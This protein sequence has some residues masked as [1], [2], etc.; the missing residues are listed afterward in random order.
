MKFEV[1]YV[2][3]ISIADSSEWKVILN[4]YNIDNHECR[5]FP[6]GEY[7]K[8]SLYNKELLFYSC[9]IRKVKS[10]A[11]TQ[12][13]IDHFDLEKIIVVGTCA[14]I[15]SNY[16]KLDVFF[17]DKLVQYDC[18]VKGIGPLINDEYTVCLNTTNFP[19]LKTGTL[20]TGDKFVALWE[21]YIELKNN[22]ITIA[23]MESA[24]IGLVCK[25]NNV[26]C[27]VVK[28]ITDYPID[29]NNVYDEQMNTFEINTPL[30]MKK[31]LDDYLEFA[32]KNKFEYI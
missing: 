1:I 5:K 7:F 30:V 21:D 20:A 10:S 9:D 6:F 19:N 13:M 31:I 28:G 29:E 32:I 22:D 11:S 2:I 12:Y 24:A 14:G 23:D 8:L 26:E 27:V 17:P 3:G 25:L 4:Y 16:D 15:D 18:N